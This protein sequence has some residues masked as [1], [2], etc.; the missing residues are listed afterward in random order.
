MADAL[1]RESQQH[2]AEQRRDGDQGEP[3][4]LGGGVH[5][6]V[7]QI[8][9]HEK[10][11]DGL[12]RRVVRKILP[13]PLEEGDVQQHLHRDEQQDDEQSAEHKP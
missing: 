3:G 8:D 5:T 4:E 10:R 2:R 1:L 7:E 13:E 6:A 9:R 12:R 11:E